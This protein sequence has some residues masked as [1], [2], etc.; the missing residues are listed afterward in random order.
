[1]FTTSSNHR[2]LKKFGL[3]VSA[4]FFF[5]LLVPF[6]GWLVPVLVVFDDDYYGT[7]GAAFI[8]LDGSRPSPEYTVH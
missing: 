8:L 7:E 4:F 2:P 5:G 6:V 1:L 3:L